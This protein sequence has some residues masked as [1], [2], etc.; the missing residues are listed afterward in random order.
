MLC[1]CIYTKIETKDKFS[2]AHH[3]HAAAAVVVVVFTVEVAVATRRY[4]FDVVILP[5]AEI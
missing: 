4:S 5:L 3:K 2:V 1:L